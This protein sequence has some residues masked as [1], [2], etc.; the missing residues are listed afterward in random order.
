MGCAGLFLIS[1]TLRFNHMIHLT[2][3]SIVLRPLTEQELPRLQRIYAGTPLYFEALGLPE[4]SLDLVRAQFEA[5]RATPG[6]TLLGVEV[7]AV[8][9]LIGALDLQVDYPAPQMATIWLLLI[10]GGFQ[11]QG[12]GSECVELI[13]EWLSAEAGCTELRVVAAPNEEGLRFWEQRGLSPAAEPAIA[14]IGSAP[15]LWLVQA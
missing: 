15:A 12:Y 11:R 5:A 13:V 1:R 4:P 2:G 3:Q 6:R 14:P 10:W 9:L 8:D 7:P